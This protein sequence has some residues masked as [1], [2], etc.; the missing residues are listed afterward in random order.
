[1]NSSFI[2]T[3][4]CLSVA[5]QRVIAL[6]SDNRRQLACHASNPA[7]FRPVETTMTMSVY[8]ECQRVSKVTVNTP[9]VKQK[10]PCVQ[11]HSTAQEPN[12][13]E[14]QG[15]P[16][17]CTQSVLAVQGETFNLKAES[18]LLQDNMSATASSSWSVPL[19][20]WDWY[21]QSRRPRLFSYC[22]TTQR[23]LRWWLEG[24]KLYTDPALKSSL[25]LFYSVILALFRLQS[26]R[27]KHKL[28]RPVEM[29]YIKKA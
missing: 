29:D 23:H 7:F 6:S 14:A 5:S 16:A 3:F 24:S 10:H 4:F 13:G 1:M 18:H 22:K 2:F 19:L 8:C 26:C 12:L 15:Y 21:G 28:I 17:L 11:A 9:S 27:A 25:V 20:G